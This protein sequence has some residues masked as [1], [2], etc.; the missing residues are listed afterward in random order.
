M[1]AL[2]SAPILLTLGVLIFW[3][4]LKLV[5]SN[6]EIKNASARLYDI[7][8]ELTDGVVSYDPDFKIVVI[9]KAAEKLFDLK[10]DDVI[11]KRLGPE[12]VKEEKFKLITQVLFPSLA[13]LVVK[14]TEGENYPQVVDISLNDPDLEFRVTTIK[15]FLPDGQVSG[16]VKI[17]R[18]RTREKELIKSKSEFITIAA[19][20]LRTPLTALNWTL[21]MLSKS[22]FVKGE[23]KDISKNG[24]IA[25]ATALKIVN[26]LLDISK[27]EEGRFGYKFDDVDVIKFLSDILNNANLS[28][29]EYGLNIYLDR[30]S[31]TKLMAKIDVNRLGLAVSNIL[32]NAMRYNVKNGT[33]TMKV[34]RKEPYIQI[35]V[36]D[37]GIGIPPEAM[38]KMFGKFFRAEN[39]VRFR[40][41]GS[42]FGLYI[43]KNIINR[44]GGNIWIES[45]L[46]RGTTVYFT[47]PT[48]SSLIP[49]KEVAYEDY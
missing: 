34:E 25:S 2:V 38:S 14:R 22:D 16:F 49:P 18:D 23:E 48:D 31:E 26:D 6:K 11:G 17:I 8:G 43:A 9:N 37:T 5:R 7:V 33:I 28:A 20:Q 13:P 41:D 4:N 30:G 21:D 10:K 39:A 47:L 3:N 45:A 32:D 24:L 1:S 12:R 27:I 35:G 40:P 19:H 42:G 15:I 29:R 36:A 46:G 44:H